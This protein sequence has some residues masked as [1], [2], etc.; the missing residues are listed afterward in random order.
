MINN[1]KLVKIQSDLGISAYLLMNK[2]N[3]QGKKEKNFYFE[4]NE[5]DELKYDEL[6]VSYLLSEFHYFDHCLMGLKKLPDFNIK[7]N[8]QFFVTD[9]GVAAYLLMHKFKLISKIGKNFYFDVS[10]DD[11]EIQFNELNIQYTNSDFHDFDSKIM[12]LKKIGSFFKKNH[13]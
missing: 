7:N 9:L 8:S 13:I 5:C 6:I 11:E 1:K 4:I 3:L 12:S 10:S 2:F